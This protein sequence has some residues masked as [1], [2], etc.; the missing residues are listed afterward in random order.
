MK[1]KEQKKIVH[2]ERPDNKKAAPK[3]G[4]ARYEKNWII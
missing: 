2:S 4:T 3:K 1:L